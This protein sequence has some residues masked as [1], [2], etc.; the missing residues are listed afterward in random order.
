MEGKQID[1][2]IFDLDGTLW[3][4][5]GTCAEAWN[6]SFKQLG[7]HHVV[8]QAFIRS[9]SGLRIEKVF[10]QYFNF[11]PSAKHSEL[12]NIYKQQEQIFMKKSGGLLFPGVKDV[13]TKLANTQKLFVVSNCLT[14]YIENFIDFTGLKN[15]FI[16]F[17]SSGNTGLPKSE[18]IQLIISRNHLRNPVYVGDTLW[19]QEA[20]AAANIPFIYASYGFGKAAN[21]QHKIQRFDELLSLFN[22]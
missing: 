12:L 21:F 7:N 14:G 20:A 22:N 1:S 11:I 18:N 17:E 10:D 15:I 6:E 19:D 5:S 9:V 2:I 3:D 8:D 4:A 13:L 16:D